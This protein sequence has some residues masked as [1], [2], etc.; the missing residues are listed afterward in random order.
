MPRLFAWYYVAGRNGR[1]RRSIPAERSFTKFKRFALDRG[2]MRPA[3]PEQ[4][5]LPD[6]IEQ[7]LEAQLLGKRCAGLGRGRGPSCLP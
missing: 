2:A 7:V 5:R 1:L 4:V 6:N 3:G